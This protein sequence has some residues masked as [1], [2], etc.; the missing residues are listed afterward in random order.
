MFIQNSSALKCDYCNT[1]CVICV[2]SLK[3]PILPCQT[4]IIIYMRVSVLKV[5]TKYNFVKLICLFVNITILFL[6]KRAA[7]C[8]SLFWDLW[9]VV[10]MLM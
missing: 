7:L 10:N 3:S 2:F 6:N 1:V 4:V 9:I 8:R 5:Y